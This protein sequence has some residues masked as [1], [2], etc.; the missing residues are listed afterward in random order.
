[1]AKLPQ[2]DEAS[3]N[4]LVEHLPSTKTPA[5]GRKRKKQMVAYKDKTAKVDGECLDDCVSNCELLSAADPEYPDVN[6]NKS[7]FQD[8]IQYQPPSNF[9]ES[10]LTIPHDLP[11]PISLMEN[12]LEALP[13]PVFKYLHGGP[14]FLSQRPS[15]ESNEDWYN[16]Y[17]VRLLFFLSDLAVSYNGNFPNKTLYYYLG[18]YLYV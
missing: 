8:L 15:S 3:F 18:S 4:N 2:N 6:K 5:K 14:N 13:S 11:S 12:T 9:I 1:M 10:S 7:S 16:L 17:R